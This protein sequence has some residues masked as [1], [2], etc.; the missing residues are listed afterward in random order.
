VEVNLNLLNV[1][2]QEV[3][4]AIKQ[5]TGFSFWYRDEEINLNKII[6]VNAKNQDVRSVLNAILSEQNLSYTIDEKHIVIY[7][8]ERGMSNLLQQQ[9]HNIKGIVTDNRGEPIIGANVIEKGTTNGIITDIN[10]KYSL[11]IQSASSVIVVSYIGYLPQDIMVGNRSEIN[12]Q[13]MENLQ[14]LEEVVVIGYGI[15]K[16]SNLTGSIAVVDREKLENRPITNA[17]Q[18]LQGVPGLYVN[19]VGGQPGA[20]AA[21]IRIRGIGTIGGA[22]K[23]NP[24]VLVDGVEYPLNDINPNDIESISVLKDAAST[25][26]YGSR[27]ANGIILVKT[28]IGKTDQS[29]VE[30]SN[31]LGFQ[32]ATFLPDAVSNSADFMEY[33]NKAIVNQGGSPYYTEEQ[34][35][36]FRTNPTS[37]LYP[38]T[39]WMDVMFRQAFVQEHNL[40]FSGGTS[41]TKYSLSGGFLDQKGVVLGSGTKRY[42]TNLRINS[43]ITKRLSIEGGIMAN[44]WDVDNLAYGM[45]NGMNRI[46]RMVPIQPLGKLPDGTWPNRRILTPGQNS[47]ENPVVM[48]EEFYRKEITDRLMLNFNLNLELFDGLTYNLNASAT[49]RQYYGKVWYPQITLYPIREGEP[50]WTWRATAQLWDNR[51]KDER[52]NTTQLLTYKK[53][54]KQKHDLLAM[55]GTSMDQYM[56]NNLGASKT[57]FPSSNDL[58]EM[59]VGNVMNAISGTSAKDV[60]LSYFGRMQ[61][62]YQDKYLFE[63]NG[64][65]DGSSRFADGYRW[66]F[67]P[68][69]SAGWRIS[70]ESFMQAEEWIDALKIRISYGSIGNQE[71]GRFQFVNSI[72]LGIGY[73][74]GETYQAGSAITQMKDERISWETTTMM[75]GGIDWVFFNGILSG[76]FDLFHRRTDGILRQVTLPAQV[77]A[78]GGP[79]SNIAVVDNTGFEL[80][81]NHNNRIGDFSYQAGFNLTKIKNKVIDLKEEII[82]SGS[83]ITQEGYAIDSWY[84]YQTDGLFRTQDDLNSSPKITSRVGLG[85]VKYVD[86]NNDGKIDGDDRYIAGNSFPDYTYGFNIGGSYKGFS[87]TTVWQG[88]QNISVWL[89]GNLILPYNNGAG[90]TKK[91]ITDSWSPENPD[92]PLPRITTRHGYTAEN[93]SPSDF[94]LQDASYLRLKNIQLAYDFPNLGFL[95]KAGVKRLKLFING[96]NLLTFTKMTD[97]D[98]EQDVSV[99]S[100]NKYPSVR[101]VTGGINL[102]F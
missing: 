87:L 34:I 53:I 97:F 21:M 6:S 64:R 85:D 62:A 94:W 96:Q 60:L 55:V 80:S 102:N 57:E 67:F 44:R 26:I 16:K 7:K 74:F 5:Q 14:A 23:L 46:F 77:G 95:T 30:Y 13:L 41:K 32:E 1:S 10:G 52:L 66:G 99:E 92:A 2:T 89:T 19:Q 100:L 50:S 69:F 38:N 98:P 68:S 49:E 78:L 65:F 51:T 25:A 28:K 35:N 79:T 27:A 58:Q 36:E 88:V 18:A 73:P 48:A 31:Y 9:T 81:L 93:F 40:R 12:I 86:R 45:E 4:D 39:D 63:M 72:A 54:F 3:L 43:E 47:Y 15:Q 71:I 8:K 70:E 84:I 33:Y 17:T 82:Y 22:A 61:Y 20:D 42:A 59:S 29:S 75:N 90:L 11:N 37:Q 24:L 83:R 56:T 76:E 101:T 91:W